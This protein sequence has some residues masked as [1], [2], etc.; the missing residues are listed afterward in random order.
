MN[1]ERDMV[2]AMPAQESAICPI[3]SLTGENVRMDR[4][5][6]YCPA[7]GQ[8][9]KMLSVKT[10]D[11]QLLKKD[12]LKIPD[13]LETNIVTSQLESDPVTNKPKQVITGIFIQRMKDY[14]NKHAQIEGQMSFF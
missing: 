9:I 2:L 12:V 4:W 7:C 6:R 3:C 11:W 5:M 14:N 13:V 8:R 10:G 1:P